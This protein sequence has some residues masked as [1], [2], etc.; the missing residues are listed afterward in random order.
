M[1]SRWAGMDDKAWRRAK[2]NSHLASTPTRKKRKKQAI[3]ATAATTTTA[4]KTPTPPLPPPP[5]TTPGTTTPTPRA[6]TFAGEGGGATAG[7]RDIHRS[8]WSIGTFP[9][10]AIELLLNPASGGALTAPSV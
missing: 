6:L 5:T 2:R 9:V 10:V 3:A 7:V 8:A 4:T 1:N